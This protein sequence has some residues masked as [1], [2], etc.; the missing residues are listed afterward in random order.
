MPGSH[1]RRS[2]RLINS[3]ALS[4]CAWAALAH[5]ATWE[6]VASLDDKGSYLVVDSESLAKAGPHQK[7]WFRWVY[8]NWQPVSVAPAE[9]DRRFYVMLELVYFNCS[10]HTAA[11]TQAIYQDLNGRVVSSW[12]APLERVRWTEVAPETIGEAQFKAACR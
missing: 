6:W 12:D 11:S 8:T 4:A 10:E 7:A 1:R 2:R 3:L 9:S 5:G